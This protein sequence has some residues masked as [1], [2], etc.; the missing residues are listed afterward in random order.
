MHRR[1]HEE[2]KLEMRIWG[3]SRGELV[4]VHML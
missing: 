1:A 4:V 3:W 2:G